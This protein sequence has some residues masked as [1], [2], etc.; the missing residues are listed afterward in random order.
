M[1]VAEI[2]QCFGGNL[3]AGALSQHFNR[4]I[5]PNAKLIQDA[6]SRGEDPIGVTLLENVRSGQPGK[7]Q[8]AP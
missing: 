7:G 3:K 4:D 8:T 5:K 2:A 6:L 1:I